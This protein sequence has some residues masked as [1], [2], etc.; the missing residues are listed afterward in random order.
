MR[1]TKKKEKWEN[2]RN[3]KFTD[4]MELNLAKEE[5]E[6]KNN[7][8]SKRSTQRAKQEHRTVSLLL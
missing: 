4:V 5:E 2:G 3:R 1:K 8:C 6:R 7:K